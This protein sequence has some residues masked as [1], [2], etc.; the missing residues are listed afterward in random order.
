MVEAYLGYDYEAHGTN[1]Y[2]YTC[3][4]NRILILRHVRIQYTSDATAGDRKLRVRSRAGGISLRFQVYSQVT[5][6]ASS[7]YH[8][9][10]NPKIS[11][12]STAAESVNVVKIWIPEIK[13]RPND[14]LE[15]I[16]IN[17]ISAS[18]SMIVHIH[19]DLIPL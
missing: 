1:A 2:T 13:L 18:D 6:P 5:Q 17:N 11:A 3:P 4:A 16:D 10:C 8:Y 7:T 19:G 12:S 14:T 9:E 15:V